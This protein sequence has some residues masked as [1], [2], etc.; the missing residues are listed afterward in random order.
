MEGDVGRGGHGVGQGGDEG[1]APGLFQLAVFFQPLGDGDHVHG[2]IGL[3]Q[4]HD[5]FKDEAVRQAVKIVAGQK[6]GG[7][8]DGL[9]FDE[10][11]P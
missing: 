9:F 10:H 6:F 5:G 8:T 1:D 7:G 2:F 4:R 11:G 3:A